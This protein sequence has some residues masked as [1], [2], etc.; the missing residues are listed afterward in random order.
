MS[1]FIRIALF[2]SIIFINAC[3]PRGETKTLA[4]VYANSKERFV[5]VQ[6]A[7]VPSE[8]AQPL[9]DIDTRLGQIA[10]QEGA[11][12]A[13]TASAIADLLTP[14]TNRAGYTARP[15]MGE[16][17]SQYRMMSQAEEVKNPS[18]K[19]LAARTYSLLASELETTKF[20]V[21]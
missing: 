1:T 20:S 7:A 10:G 11:E 3:A 21:Q 13:K 19:L 14:L 8:I 5:T 6:S 18:A 15:A 9:K 2:S 16:I 4:E 12:A 17:I